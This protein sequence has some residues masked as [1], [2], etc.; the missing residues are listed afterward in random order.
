MKIGIVREGKNPPDKRVPFTPQQCITIQKDYPEVNLVVQPSNVRCFSDDEYSNLGIILQEDLSDCDVLFGIKEVLVEDLIQ[1]KTYFYF[2]HTHKLQP[3]NRKLIQAILQKKITHI[4]YECLTYENG[5]RV[6]GFGRYAGIV[7]AYNGLKTYGLRHKIFQLKPAHQCTDLSE[8]KIELT[9]TKM[10][11]AKIILTGSGRVAKGAHEILEAAGIRKVDV[12][13]FLAHTFEHAVYCWIDANEY[14]AH[15]DGHEFDYNHFFKNGSDY[16]STFERFT[17]VS[18]LYIA[19][20]FWDNSSPVFFTADMAASE[21]FNISVIADISCD[22][23]CAIPST[24]RPSTIA[25]PVYD[26]DPLTGSEA[27]P[28]SDDSNIS[29]MAVDNLPCELPVDASEGFGAILIKDILPLVIHGD[30]NDILER[31]TFTNDQGQLTERF[32]YMSDFVLEK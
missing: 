13:H 11:S 31:A 16:V 6:I 32:A 23:A 9:K 25:A 30:K 19:G 28:Y 8:M 18:D 27:S 10:G 3:Y 20:H 21:D 22:I 17:K 5:F 2:S 1:N 24:L 14:V 4:D 29:V 15:K 12:E 26:Y 7:G